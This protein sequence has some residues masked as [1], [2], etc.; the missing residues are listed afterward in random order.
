MA[1]VRHKISSIAIILAFVAILVVPVDAGDVRPLSFNRDIRPIFAEHCFTC[2]GQ[3]AAARKAGLRLDTAEGATRA[4]KSGAAAIVPGDTEASVLLHRITT[5]ESDERMPPAEKG[6]ALDD[7]SIRKLRAWIA[8]GA[9]FES[10]WAYIA[11][12]KSAV[13]KVADTAWPRNGIDR[14][15]LARL[16]TEGFRPAPQA[17][18]YTLLRRMSF[19]LIG[20]PPTIAEADAFAKD[21]RADALDWVLDRLLASPHYG[22]H[23]ARY[24]L[25]LARYADS[26]GY[27]IDAPRS[28]WP[29]RDWVIR[30]YNRN[31]PFDEFTRQQLAGDLLPDA[32]L[33]MK[34]ATGFH[35]NTLINEEGGIDPEEFRSKAVVDRV[36]TT[37]TVWQGTTIT[38]AQCHDHK[39]DPFSQKEFYQLYAFFN[40]VPEL[41]GGTFQSRAP[42]VELT[43]DPLLQA[44]LDGLASVIAKLEGDQPPSPEKSEVEAKKDTKAPPTR[45]ETLRKQFEE[46]RKEIV[47]SLTMEEM[48]E[49]REA[50]ILTRGDFLQPG[51]V[52]TA[53]TPEVLPPMKTVEGVI[54]NRLD[55][56]NWLTAPENP[57]TARVAVNRL[58]QQLFGRGLVPTP[59]DFGTRGK[60]PSH[61]ELLDYL[62][63][64]FVE[65]G[66]DVKG[67]LRMILSSATYQQSASIG[68]EGYARDPD[69]VLLARGPRFRLDGETIRDNALAVSGLLTREVGGPG[70]YPY[71]PPGLWE[72]KALTGYGAGIWPDTTGPAL[73]R[74]GLYTFRRRSVPYP[75]FQAF[76]APGFEYCTAERSRTNTPL[77]A[78]TTM[79]DPQFVEAARVF[80]QRI[81][82]EGGEDLDAQIT[83]ALR[84][85]LTRPPREEERALFTTLYKEQH[86]A[87]TENPEA[88]EQ[89]I[90]QGRAPVPN[91]LDP[92]VLA[93]WTTIANILLNLDETVT[94]G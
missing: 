2:H 27:H 92:A 71:Q 64:T 93:T 10:H 61:P 3:D 11:P 29:Y 34:I 26:N 19:D 9:E 7:P 59:E 58:W 79:N 36:N 39:Y 38:C 87:F 40:N 60:P 86:T 25:D 31:M 33:E 42:L 32:T 69:N 90:Q 81:L 8:Q 45:L 4:L 57:L 44:E 17:D 52:V 84:Q 14:F 75:T 15:V 37:M 41:G 89:L 51:D 50:H 74:R 72:E 68:S 65:N 13:P 12:V 53:A 55:L 43:P 24:W 67:L 1:T 21:E 88:A 6:E 46:K 48:A 49:P 22:E 30:A 20:L 16:E 56:A 66:W 54:P 76:D 80:G 85:C 78:L 83:F 73:Y 63:V 18:R 28:M 91:D 23:R 5:T 62:A 82:R 70:V 35:R 94:K 47:T 77:Q